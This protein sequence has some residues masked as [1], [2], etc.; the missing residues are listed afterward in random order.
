MGFGQIVVAMDF[1]EASIRA[2]RRAASLLG[3]DSSIHLVHVIDRPSRGDEAADRDATEKVKHDLFRLAERHLDGARSAPV[4]AHVTRGRP[5]ERILKRARTCHADLIIVGSHA[6]GRVARVVLGSV[7]E[8]LARISEIPVLIVR[9]TVASEAV[10]DRV[11]VALD[12]TPHSRI[13]ARAGVALAEQ[14][15]VEALG[16]SVVPETIVPGASDD[17]R[18]EIVELAGLALPAET[19]KTLRGR[20]RYARGEP[21]STI[22][23]MARSRDI[24]VCGTHGRSTLGRLAFGS[25]ATKLVRTVPCPIL[26]V[27]PSARADAPL[28]KTAVIRKRVKL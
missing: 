7:S 26:V 6:R 22:A 28:A 14:L 11:L 17:V 2:L 24:V 23:G 20:V 1:S 5:A 19:M 18:A 4:H 15:G 27:R 10:P 12:A 25:V 3:P 8:E 13:A 16:V 21:S 9:E